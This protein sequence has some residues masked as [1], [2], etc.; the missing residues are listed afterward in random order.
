STDDPLLTDRSG[1]TRRQP[2]VRVVLDET[3]R[4][5]TD[6]KLASTANEAPVIVFA[7][8][9]VNDSQVRQLETRGVQIVSGEAKDLNVVLAE[10]GQR[11]IQSVLVEGG[12]NV[13][14][15]FFDAGLVNKVSFFIAPLIIGGREAPPAVG[16]EGAQSLADAFELEDLEIIPHGRDLE[17]TGYPKRRQRD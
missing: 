12:A 14:G 11:S 2:L 13:A 9:A 4:L 5:A 1:K 17:V 16:G 15:K 8:T 7:G 3:L 10:L 6:S